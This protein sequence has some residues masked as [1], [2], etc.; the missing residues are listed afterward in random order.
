MGY[1]GGSNLKLTVVSAYSH[2]LCV[3]LGHKAVVY[4]CTAHNCA[5]YVPKKKKKK[6]D[7]LK[8][9]WWTTV[10]LHRA[11]SLP[12]HR[13]SRASVLWYS[14]HSHRSATPALTP[15]TSNHQKCPNP[16]YCQPMLQYL[17]QASPAH[18]PNPSFSQD[19]ERLPGGREHDGWGECPSQDHSLPK[20]PGSRCSSPNNRAKNRLIHLEDSG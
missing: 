1:P 2:V 10:I 19:T 14:W 6:K 5:I 13:L 15:S 7:N 4:K 12:G 3:T 17:Q 11:A 8:I 16:Y 9:W 18:T 20:A